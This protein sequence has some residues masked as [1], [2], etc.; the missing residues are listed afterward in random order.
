MD[1][2]ACP[3]PA[4]PSAWTSSDG[5]RSDGRD[6]PSPPDHSLHTGR[7]CAVTRHPPPPCVWS[8]TVHLHL[9]VLAIRRRMWSCSDI[10]VSCR[11]KLMK[12]RSLQNKITENSSYHSC[13]SADGAILLVNSFSNI[14]VCGVNNTLGRIRKDCPLCY[15]NFGHEVKKPFY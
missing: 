8:W 10:K 12:F 3:L 14:G 5:R 13:R 6:F 1:T 4:A 11:G 15:Y 7:I 2:T 9:V